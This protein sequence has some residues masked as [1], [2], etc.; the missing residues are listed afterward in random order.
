MSEMVERVAAAI[1]GVL[2]GD[3]ESLSMEMGFGSRAAEWRA[4]AMTEAARAAI[5]AMR[6]RNEPMLDA[7]TAVLWPPGKPV[8][9]PGT[10]A[11]AVY[12]AMIDAALAQPPIEG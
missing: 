3:H 10:T 5:A 7:G 2:G 6:E 12:E 4:Q 11:V 1:D 8:H 9:L